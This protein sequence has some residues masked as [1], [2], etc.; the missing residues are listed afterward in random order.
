MIKPGRSNFKIQVVS[1]ERSDLVCIAC[2]QFRTNFA[3]V[4][5]G[6]SDEHAHVGVHK[7][8]VDEIKVGGVRKARLDADRTA[9]PKTRLIA[10]VR[11]GDC[12]RGTLAPDAHEDLETGVRTEL[13]DDD[14]KQALLDEL[15]S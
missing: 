15:T 7:R 1:T 11:E 2:G 4:V 9:K 10:H 3:V 8:C 13:A 14:A 6:E 5:E 12:V